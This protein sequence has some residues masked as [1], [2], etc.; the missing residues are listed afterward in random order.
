MR[1]AYPMRVDALDKPGGDVVLMRTYIQQC[2]TLSAQRGI[3]FEGVLLTDLEP[4][5]SSFDVVHLTNLDRPVDLYQ[6]FKAAQRAGKR[7][8]LTPLHHSYEEIGRYE[9]LGRG[10]AIG[11][12]SGVLGFNQLEALRIVVKSRRYPRLLSALTKMLQKG[13]RAAQREI[14][15][16]VDLV[17]VAAGKELADIEREFCQLPRER[18]VRVRNGFAMPQVGL[19]LATAERDIDICVMGRIEARKNQISILKAIESLGLSAVFVG[20][21]NPNHKSYCKRFREKIAHSKSELLDGV[22]HE[23]AGRILARSRVH[24]AASWFEVS[25]LLDIESYVLG[26]RVVASECGG[27]REL[28]GDDAYYVDPASWRSIARQISLALESSRQGVINSAD[29][30]GSAW[31]T[32]DKIGERM[33]AIYGDG[34]ESD[35]NPLG[36]ELTLR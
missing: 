10:G 8:V 14:L 5:L 20:N 23:E 19:S 36:G 31:E 13:V 3:P 32:W 33:L 11:L 29:L 25:S 28:L 2:A 27:T 18:V 9:K 21:E 30:T 34:K 4:D 12:F 6:Q 16:G 1:V 35:A 24:V 15:L 17:L 26:C 7:M 22:P